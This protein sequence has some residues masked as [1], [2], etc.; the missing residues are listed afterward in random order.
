MVYPGV[1]TWA[2]TP[3]GIPT[4]VPRLYTTLG[5]PHGTQA[6]HHLGYTSGYTGY[7]PPRVYHRVYT[8]PIPGYTT[9]CTLPTIPGYTLWCQTGT[10]RR[11]LPLRTMEERHN[12]ARLSSQNLRRKRNN[13]ACLSLILWEE[14]GNNEARSI[15][16]SLLKP[17]ITRR[18]LSPFFGRNGEERGE[19]E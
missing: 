13:E 6:I 2:Y 5:I 8:T 11:V 9:G 14:R 1:Y 12:E 19:E 17:A 16:L 18:V 10:T 4:M 3:G 7:T 15:P